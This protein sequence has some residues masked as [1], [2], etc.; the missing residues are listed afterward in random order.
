MLWTL[1]NREGYLPLLKEDIMLLPE[2]TQISELIPLLDESP[3]EKKTFSSF[4]KIYSLSKEYLAKTVFL[5]LKQTLETLLSLSFDLR[6]KID[7]AKF[8]YYVTI[9]ELSYRQALPEKY[10]TLYP[11]E[12]KVDQKPN[13]EKQLEETKRREKKLLESLRNY[14]QFCRY[15]LVG[16]IFA[17]PEPTNGIEKS[18]LM[19]IFNSPLTLNDLHRE[20][21]QLR[22]KHHPD[23]SPFPEVK[24]SAIFF[25][26]KKAY[27][28]L[29]QSWDKFD[30]YN[31]EIPSSRVEK[32]LNQKL[33]FSLQDVRYW[34]N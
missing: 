5:E 17:Q 12:G 32:L 24:A 21:K 14:E 33:T 3:Y 10:H 11:L 6:R 30:P 20:Y 19:S 34:E 18:P 27:Q 23:I 4:L 8:G 16:K 28:T 1:K 29:T 13:T 7:R 22:I 26:L 9:S 25:W 15:L 31:L 2:S